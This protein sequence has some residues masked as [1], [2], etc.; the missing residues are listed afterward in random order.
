MSRMLINDHLIDVPLDMIARTCACGPGAY[1]FIEFHGF[2]I[3]TEDTSEQ[4]GSLYPGVF[5]VS[6]KDGNI[7][8]CETLKDARDLILS[9]ELNSNGE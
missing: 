2:E 8:I 3:C 7:A 6:C 5:Y 9:V 4:P 1:D